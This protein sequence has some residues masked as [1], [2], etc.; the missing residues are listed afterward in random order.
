MTL[1]VQTTYSNG[2]NNDDFNDYISSIG[3]YNIA[4][5]IT[6]ELPVNPTDVYIFIV[7]KDLG[8]EIDVTNEGRQPRVEYWYSTAKKKFSTCTIYFYQ[9]GDNAEVNQ[10]FAK[11]QLIDDVKKYANVDEVKEALKVDLGVQ[12]IDIVGT[13]KDPIYCF[14]TEDIITVYSE[15]MRENGIGHLPVFDTDSEQ[16]I[17]LISDT[18]ILPYTVLPTYPKVEGFSTEKVRALKRSDLDSRKKVSECMTHLVNDNKD[19]IS[20]ILPDETPMEYLPKFLRLDPDNPGFSLLDKPAHNLLMVLSESKPGASVLG[21]I[22]WVDIFKNWEKISASFNFSVNDLTVKDV[23][24]SLEKLPDIDLRR[25]VLRSALDRKETAGRHRH[26]LVKESGEL[27]A[28]YHFHE[29]YPYDYRGINTYVK[30]YFGQLEVGGQSDKYVVGPKYSLEKRTIPDDTKIWTRGNP[31]CAIEIFKKYVIGE[32]IKWQDRLAGL[33]L[34]NKK[35]N[36]THLL[37]PYNIIECL[38]EKNLSQTK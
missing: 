22:S 1:H 6:D 7:N 25:N 30:D 27:I 37:N 34:T 28:V 23:A 13:M 8:E 26:I 3:N 5:P 19:L 29:L 38:I 21:V 16:L 36:F 2:L 17:G 15:I 10:F 31:D 11:H 24:V 12:A 20:H 4:C 35:G 33:L 18:D 14:D 32:G 9:I